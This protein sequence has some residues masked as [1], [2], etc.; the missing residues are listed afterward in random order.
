MREQ[1]SGSEQGIEA[2]AEGERVVVSWAADEAL[3][4]EEGGNG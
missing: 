1:R 3:D 2:L 4:L